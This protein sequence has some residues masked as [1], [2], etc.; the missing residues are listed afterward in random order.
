MNL[1]KFTLGFAALALSLMPSMMMAQLNPANYRVG[2]AHKVQLTDA[3]IQGLNGKYAAGQLPTIGQ[4]VDALKS[5]KVALAK[6]RSVA[7]DSKMSTRASYTASDTIFWESFESWDGQTFDYIPD[8][9]TEYSIAKSAINTEY[10]FNP[11]WQTFQTDGFY[12]PYATD[13]DYVGMISYSYDIYDENENLIQAAPEQDEWLV[14]PQTDEIAATNYLSFDLGYAMISLFDISNEEEI[15]FDNRTF[16]LEVLVTTNSRRPSNNPEDYTSIFKLSDEVKK[17]INELGT[18]S[19]S[20]S[21]LMNF[22]WRHFCISLKEFAGENLR[23]AF[24]YTGKNGGNIL[25]DAFRVS[26]LLPV[27]K[28]AVPESSFFFGLSQELYLPAGGQAAAV[29][30]PADRETVWQ[31]MSNADARSYQWAY[32]QVNDTVPTG[33]YDEENLVLS[34]HNASGMIAMPS[35]TAVGE[36]K[37]D[38]YSKYGW[39]KYGGN[40]MLETDGGSILFGAGNYDPT[41]GHWSAPLDD[42]GNRYL[43]G[44]GSEAFFGGTEGLTGK[45]TGVANMYEQPSS[46]YMIS[47]VWVPL[48]KFT[49]LTN[50][51][52]FNC[53]IYRVKIADDGSIT[54]TDEIIANS[55]TTSKDVKANAISTGGYNMV[56]NFDEPVVINEPVLIYVDGFQNNNVLS[57][58][59]LAQALGHDSDKNY[60]FLSLE[61]TNKSYI[62]YELEGLLT[63]ADGVGNAKSSFCIFHN[64]VYPFLYSKEGYTFEIPAAG[65][66][67]SFECDTYFD[68]ADWTVEGMPSWATYEKVLD[69]EANTVKLKFTAEVLPADVAGRSA[70]VKVT[71]YCNEMT[72]TLLQGDAITGIEGVDGVKTVQARIAENTLYLDYTS[73][74]TSVAVYNAGGTLVKSASLPASG[75][76]TINAAD[77]ARGTYIVRFGGKSHPVV[78]VVK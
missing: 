13:G 36:N 37:S 55:F 7:N 23:I 5:N 49:S 52:Q 68:P 54:V 2:L 41:K 45:V 21:E 64:A 24:R 20:A 22:K 61:T 17:Q 15:N 67:K 31:N 40:T 33:S 70:N 75:S 69:A 78:K 66:E 35:L 8:G 77:L 30:L 16:E 14:S 25:V 32:Y 63:N 46:P 6:T 28:Y 50:N 34:A 57:I 53:Y 11:T 19:T 72:F 58:A 74:I 76:A 10:E 65:G 62:L 47:T 43:F 48:L 18:D 59:A 39:F 51:V 42:S 71:S 9:W 73:D 1:K 29:L 3:D 56:F 4:A 12:A 27:A 38:T 26:D 60:A 44:T